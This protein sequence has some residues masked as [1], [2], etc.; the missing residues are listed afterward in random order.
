MDE[1]QVDAIFETNPDTAVDFEITIAAFLATMILAYPD[2]F[3]LFEPA[4][5]CVV[6]LLLFS[7]L[8]RRIGIINSFYNSRGLF[9]ITKPLLVIST[10]YSLFYF[11]VQLSEITR[12]LIKIPRGV[13]LLIFLLMLTFL[14]IIL[15]ELIFEELFF[16][17]AVA[18]HNEI[19]SGIQNTRFRNTFGRIVDICLENTTV[20][21]SEW[22]SQLTEAYH[23]EYTRDED[24]TLGERIGGTL[25]VIIAI[26]ITLLIFIFLLILGYSLDPSAPFLS[27]FS[28]VLLFISVFSTD[29]FTRILYARYAY[30]HPRQ[31]YFSAKQTLIAISVIAVCWASYVGLLEWKF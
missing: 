26:F 30:H 13:I 15:Y 8:I 11:S 31:S 29:G 1:I 10:V 2:A 21:R 25:G 9:A 27:I 5:Y 22:P 18:S 20:P 24:A 7:T 28:G 3:W 14:P 17:L 4:N 6:F 23:G 19:V 12:S 16:F